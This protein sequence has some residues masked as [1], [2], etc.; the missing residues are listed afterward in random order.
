[1][2]KMYMGIDPGAK[3]FITTYFDGLW[4]HYSIEDNDLLG[5]AKILRQIKE[6]HPQIACVIEEVHALFG[7]SAKSTFSFGWINGALIALL[8][9]NEIP[10]TLVQPKKW[11][12]A[13]WSNK[14]MVVTFKK[15]KRKDKEITK[16]DV[17]T[18]QTSINACRRLFPSLDLRKSERAKNPDDN[19]VDSI[20]ICEYARRMNL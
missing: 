4:R 14:D 3:G 9:A 13:I 19:K 2:S 17:N 16:K 12:A 5:L 20:L 11:Q 18:K 7:S 6:M 8:I 15:E 1:M 10:Y